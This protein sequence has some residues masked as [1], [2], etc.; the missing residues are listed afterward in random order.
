MRIHLLSVPNTQIVKDAFPLDGFCL[1]TW[2]FAELC[3]RLGHQVIL[4]GVERTDAPCTEFVQVM[5]DA[6]RLDYIGGPQTPYQYVR[7]DPSDPLFQAFNKDMGNHLRTRKQPGDVLATIVGGASHSIADAHPD[8]TFL[9]YSVGYTGIAQSA[10]RVYQSYAWQHTVYGFTGIQGG[11]A[12]DAVIPPWF[13]LEEFPYTARP[14]PYVVYCGRLI[15]NK[16][17]AIA[18]EAAKRAGMKLLIVG[19]GDQNLVTHGAEFLGA[20]STPERNQLLSQATACLMP[21]QY[22]EPFG[23]VAAEAQLCGTPMITTDYGA[24]VESVEQG[25]TGYRCNS[26]GEFIQAI[27]LAHDLDRSY[28]RDRAKR[29]YTTEAAMLSY[30]AYFRRLR[31]LRDEG[32]RDLT[33]GL[34]MRASVAA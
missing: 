18:C 29:L 8:L 10:H 31:A 26:L 23:N 11:R 9:E 16:G 2:L 20:V 34:P 6:Q 14:D 22:L 19:H 15:P 17:L 21:T 32:W 25:K 7:F 28:I 3:H 4:Y 12:C 30:T 1:R 5:T 33:P 27:D 24:F 13:P